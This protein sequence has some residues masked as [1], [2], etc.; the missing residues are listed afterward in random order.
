MLKK[1]KSA[2]RVLIKLV[3][4]EQG[5]LILDQR[6]DWYSTREK[7]YEEALSFIDSVI[8][9]NG[10]KDNVSVET[11]GKIL[12]FL[13]RY[14]ELIELIDWSYKLEPKNHGLAILKEYILYVLGKNEFALIH[15]DKIIKDK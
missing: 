9:E 10:I 4:L 8:L 12:G 14:D 6:F 7:F 13:Q 2:R 3:K 11:K 5:A 15:I 1:Q